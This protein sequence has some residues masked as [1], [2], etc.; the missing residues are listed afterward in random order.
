MPSGRSPKAD[1]NHSLNTFNKFVEPEMLTRISRH[2]A[3]TRIRYSAILGCALTGTFGILLLD[4]LILRP[5][6]N[7]IADSKEVLYSV[8]VHSIMARVS[9]D[10]FFRPLE[11]LVLTVANDTYLPLWLGVSLLCVVGATILSA[12]A[13]EKLFQR[14]LPKVGWWVL[15]VANPL[16][17]YLVS[18]PGTVSQCLCNL[19][20]AGGILILFTD[21]QQARFPLSPSWRADRLAASLNLIAAVLFFT[22]ETAV[23]AAVLLPAATTLVRLK[24]GRGLSYLF[25][26]SLLLPIGAACIWILIKLPFVSSYTNSGWRYSLTLSP[27]T[28]VENFIMTLAFP[29]TPL[30]SSLIGFGVLRYVWI[31]T[32]LMF[33]TV[34]LICIY[35]ISKRNPNIIFPFLVV[36]G[37]CAPMILIHSS[38]LYAS[39]IGPFTVSGVLLF[40]LSKMPLPS[41]IYGVLLYVGSLGNGIVYSLGPDANLLGFQHF[42]YSIYS[43]YYQHDPTCPIASTASIAWRGTEFDCKR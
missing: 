3:T 15:G 6:V 34:L 37:S 17:F 26:S 28:W 27:I 40:A 35:S 13:C 23:A 30:P 10:T 20:F 12:L 33:V 21:L 31:A 38:E 41:F 42:Q 11:Y 29:V 7:Y 16:L 36:G 1:K 18:T 5:G 8:A 32:S 22:K 39:M 25:L 9:N 14:Q 19:L 24:A 2:F 43:K 4:I